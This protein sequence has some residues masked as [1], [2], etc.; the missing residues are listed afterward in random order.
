MSSSAAIVREGVMP[1]V[2]IELEIEE[3][4]RLK[5]HAALACRSMD[6]LIKEAIALILERPIRGGPLTAKEKSRVLE[7][8][9]I[10]TLCEKKARAIFQPGEVFGVKEFM[11]RLRQAS[12]AETTPTAKE[13]ALIDERAAYRLLHARSGTGK[14]FEPHGDA[15]FSVRAPSDPNPAGGGRRRMVLNKGA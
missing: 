10:T 3:H 8:K 11:V 5:A 4:I 15:R 14:T 12:T 1:R 2:A 13:V 9:R 7:K 6:A